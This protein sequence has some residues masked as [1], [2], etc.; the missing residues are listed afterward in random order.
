MASGSWIL[1]NL[2]MVVG[3]KEGVCLFT[4]LAAL[5]KHPPGHGTEGQ[6]AALLAGVLFPLLHPRF[7]GATSYLLQ[8]PPA[9][10]WRTGSLLPD[11]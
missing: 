5:S 7:P 8:D 1:P 2:G 4:V 6:R 10:H 11:L 3:R 9:R